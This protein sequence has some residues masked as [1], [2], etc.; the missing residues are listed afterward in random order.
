[1]SENNQNL[2]EEEDKMEEDEDFEQIADE[3]TPEELVSI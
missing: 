2:T 1:M 3:L